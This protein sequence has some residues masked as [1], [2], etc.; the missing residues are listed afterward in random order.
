MCSVHNIPTG[1][2]TPW[3]TPKKTT[4]GSS[5]ADVTDK[6][7]TMIVTPEGSIIRIGGPELKPE[8]DPGW[9]ERKAERKAKKA[10]LVSPGSTSSPHSSPEMSKK[11]PTTTT[12]HPPPT[13]I[14]CG[15]IGSANR[16]VPGPLTSSLYAYVRGRN[17]RQERR[18]DVV[19]AHY[20]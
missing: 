3:T 18:A 5:Q 16:A 12:S 20:S 15:D 19:H 10:H 8:A 17:A 1:D 7:K 4:E 11:S 9:E 13:L 2:D 6:Y 14:R